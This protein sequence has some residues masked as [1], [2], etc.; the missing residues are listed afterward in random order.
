MDENMGIKKKSVNK[1]SL[2]Q[3]SHFR[4]NRISCITAPHRPTVGDVLLVDRLKK[5]II[6]GQLY[7]GRVFL[8]LA[9]G[10]ESGDHLM[11]CPIVCR[12]SADRLSTRCMLPDKKTL[13]L[14]KVIGEVF[15]LM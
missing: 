1:L 2:A 14:I 8:D 10:S 11:R 15:F 13:W 4:P 3:S 7:F 12:Q 6:T 5:N 9:I